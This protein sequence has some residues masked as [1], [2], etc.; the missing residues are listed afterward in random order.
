MPPSFVRMSGANCTI[1]GCI[2]SRKNKGM[3][4]FKV[5]LAN[6]VFNKKWSQDLIHIIL[7]YEQCDRSLNFYFP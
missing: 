4:T 6:N 7:K 5:P 2:I 3:S 1:L